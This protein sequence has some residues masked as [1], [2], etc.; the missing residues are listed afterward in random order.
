MVVDAT[1]RAVLVNTQFLCLSGTHAHAQAHTHTEPH[2]HTEPHKHT[3][4]HSC[5]H[6]RTHTHTLYCMLLFLLVFVAVYYNWS[7]KITA[8]TSDR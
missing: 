6:A 2:I 5:M 7:N 4:I 3:H 1:T 8:T